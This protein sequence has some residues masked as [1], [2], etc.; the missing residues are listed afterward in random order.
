VLNT[1]FGTIVN[2]AQCVT[3]PISL[4]FGSFASTMLKTLNSVI[5]KSEGLGAC[6]VVGKSGEDFQSQGLLHE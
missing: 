5:A 1:L 3:K 4:Q 2:V 6:Q